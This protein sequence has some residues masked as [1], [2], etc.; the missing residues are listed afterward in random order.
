M[1]IIG[2]TFEND[3]RIDYYRYYEPIKIGYNVVVENDSGK[4]FA[5]VATEIHEIDEDK[6]EMTLG[7]I[8]RV[9]TKDDYKK[10]NDNKK[11]EIS[12]IKKSNELIKKYKLDMKVLD[13]KFTLNKDQLLIRFYSEG[14]VDF[15]NLAKDLAAIYKTRIELRQIGVRDKAKIA[16]GV[17]VCGQKLCCSR[18]LKN[19]DSVSIAMA[20]NQ[21]LALNPNKI[22]G[23]CGRLMCCL[24][25]E[26]HCYT[27]FKKILPTV[28]KKVNVNGINGK[29]ISID[30]LRKKYKVELENG[31]VIEEI[32]SESN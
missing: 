10:Y 4:Y 31:T 2:V 28:G 23:V 24:K 7:R 22:N 14:R 18:F 26:N 16:G 13:A 3:E 12:V 27:C 5:T 19:F 21:D 15:R 11:K 17:G 1:K 6:L 8:L 25:Y 20:K 32:V 9:S 29:V 30:V